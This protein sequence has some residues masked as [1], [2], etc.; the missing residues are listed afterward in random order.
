[1]ALPCC[2]IE[3][4]SRG[5]VFKV[6]TITVGMRVWFNSRWDIYLANLLSLHGSYQS[7]IIGSHM[8][9][10]PRHQIFAPPMIR[11]LNHVINQPL[12]AS[13]VLRA[14]RACQPIILDG[15]RIDPFLRLGGLKLLI[16]RRRIWVLEPPRLDYYF[17]LVW[18]LFKYHGLVLWSLTILRNMRYHFMRCLS[19]SGGHHLLRAWIVVGQYIFEVMLRG[20]L[21]GG[22]LF[23]GRFF[24]RLSCRLFPWRIIPDND[25]HLVV[26]D[27][28]LIARFLIACLGCCRPVIMSM[29]SERQL[30]ALCG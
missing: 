28:D 14:G 17:M 30:V 10:T 18:F 1:M 8:A 13:Q 26:L 12:C 3:T 21:G 20:C 7:S 22:G 23:R 2:S 19:R 27:G 4:Y 11:L 5:L 9:A 25:D 15:F 24:G 16:F 29:R 6:S